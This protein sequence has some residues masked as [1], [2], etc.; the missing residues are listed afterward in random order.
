MWV[1]GASVI[2]I[3]G[4]CGEREETLGGKSNGGRGAIGRGVWAIS[5]GT[6]RVEEKGCFL[7]SSSTF[8]FA[9]SFFFVF[10]FLPFRNWFFF[11]G[12]RPVTKVTIS[13]S[14]ALLATRRFL[15]FFSFFFSLYS[16]IVSSLGSCSC[17]SSPCIVV[18]SICA[19]VRSTI[20]AGKSR[21]YRLL[22]LVTLMR[23]GCGV[24]GR[25]QSVLVDG[26]SGVEL[27]VKRSIMMVCSVRG[28]EKK[29]CSSGKAG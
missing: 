18:A 19:S 3:F 9:F 1:L 21:Q 25:G 24:E 5:V 7:P 4:I 14:P 11:P 6:F 27:A 28:K 12:S 23:E 13:S 10:S 20:P 16:S 15:S 8:L 26:D 29:G 17:S 2:L 22:S